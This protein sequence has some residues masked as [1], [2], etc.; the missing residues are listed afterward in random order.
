VLF[1]PV[2]PQ[3]FMNYNGTLLIQVNALVEST[4]HVQ[5]CLARKLTRNFPYPFKKE[6]CTQACIGVTLYS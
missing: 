5:F 2:V 3:H 6:L 1:F 4:Q